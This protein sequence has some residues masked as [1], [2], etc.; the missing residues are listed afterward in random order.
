MTFDE[1]LSRAGGA[2]QSGR[3]LSPPCSPRSARYWFSSPA[4]SDHGEWRSRLCERPQ[5]AFETR[6][7]DVLTPDNTSR[8]RERLPTFSGHLGL[9]SRME[10][11]LRDSNKNRTPAI[12]MNDLLFI[13]TCCNRRRSRHR[14][15][16]KLRWASRQCD[17]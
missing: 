8:R 15:A 2:W 9:I 1:E 14:P 12:I 17:G 16:R 5:P 7:E 6:H 3:R 11:S 4:I 10:S 13:P